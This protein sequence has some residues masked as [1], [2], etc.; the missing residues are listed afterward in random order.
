ME[1]KIEF[2]NAP[3]WMEYQN[4]EYKGPFFHRSTLEIIF[5]ME[6]ELSIEIYDEKYVLKAGEFTSINA[7]ITHILR[8]NKDT[9][10]T[11]L[12]L[13]LNYYEKEYP[14]IHGLSFYCLYR[15]DGSDDFE[16]YY[17]IRNY[18]IRLMM[19]E[20]MDV[21]QKPQM[22]KK[23]CDTLV[24][25][26]IYHVFDAQFIKNK[27]NVLKPVDKERLFS[28]TQYLSE[29]FNQQGLTLSD[30][31]ANENLSTTRLSHFWKSITNISFM[32][33]IGM[34]RY[35]EAK[36]LLMSRDLSVSEISEVCG[37]SDEKYLYK[38][39]K[40]KHGM[41][42]K[43]FCDHHKEILKSPDIYNP[44][45]IIGI[46]EILVDYA[47]NFYYKIT[48]FSFLEGHPEAIE[49]EERLNILYDVVTSVEKKRIDGEVVKSVAAGISIGRN[50]GLRYRDGKFE[51]NWEYM[52]LVSRIAMQFF[53][54]SRVI[55]SAELMSSEE[56]LE[57]FT[58]IRTEVMKQ[59]GETFNPAIHLII[60]YLSYENY[61]DALKLEETL[62]ETEYFSK[63]S[64]ILNL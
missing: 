1:I 34:Y 51:I 8:G 12:Y 4:L 58:L 39:F 36:R 13:D 2:N 44:Y 53:A 9:Y 17:V 56:W 5:V 62:R 49:E 55:I 10:I 27:I 3:Y 45:S 43:E 28:I 14:Y 41:T 61:E 63:I 7:G 42:P 31:A 47:A 60:T 57:I 19:I 21:A 23:I 46:Y 18:F 54:N 20:H 37:Y 24:N 64:T 30:L 26:L 25:V 16:L 32:E 33:T 6:G 29:H 38:V 52:Y 15:K 50:Y 40:Q 59:W 22:A 48:D 35:N 11:S